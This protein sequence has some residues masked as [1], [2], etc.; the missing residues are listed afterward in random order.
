MNKKE[1]KEFEKKEWSELDK[2]TALEI[3]NLP[4]ECQ[5]SFKNKLAEF[6]SENTYKQTIDNQNKAGYSVYVLASITKKTCAIKKPNFRISNL[7]MPYVSG[8]T[9]YDLNKASELIL[10]ECFLTGDKEYKTDTELIA[11]VA[12]EVITLMKM[13]SGGLKKN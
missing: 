10:N 7:A 9:D 11:E 1:I 4:L 13:S 5:I 12:T 3:N 8:M 6:A 2:L